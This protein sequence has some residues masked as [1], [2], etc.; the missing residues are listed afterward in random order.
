MTPSSNDS[1]GMLPPPTIRP[2]TKADLAAV[3]RLEGEAFGAEGYPRFFVRQAWDLW[4]G[5][6]LVAEVDG[7][8]LGYVL[9]GSGEDP[10]EAWILSLA[11]AP[12][13]RRMGL[14][15]ALSEAALAALGEGRRVWLTVSPASPAR[16]LYEGLG[17]VETRREDDYFGPDEARVVMVRSP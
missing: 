11:V 15:R 3:H 12:S 8:L 6:L 17:F 7:E 5:S 9:A 10:A 2:A 14:G 16:R 4:P 13:A 1:H